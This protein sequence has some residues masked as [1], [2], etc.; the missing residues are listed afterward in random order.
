LLVVDFADQL[1]VQQVA[2][3]DVNQMGRQVQAPAQRSATRRVCAGTGVLLFGDWKT[4][5]FHQLTCAATRDP[6]P[7]ALPGPAV[8]GSVKS[9]LALPEIGARLRLNSALGF[10]RFV[11]LRPGALL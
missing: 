11:Q 10:R 9:V 6:K 1:G 2:D 3:Q 4:P 7:G 8:L 5:V